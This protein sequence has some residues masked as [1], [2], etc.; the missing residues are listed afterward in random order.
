M[1]NVKMG[2]DISSFK[3]GIA[4]AKSEVKTLDQQ[5]KMLDAT[6]KAEGRSEQTLN[7]QMQTLN[8]RMTAQKSIANQAEAALKAMSKNG[9]DPAS[10]AYQRMARE[11]LAAQTGM[12]ETQSTLNDLGNGA[13]K[14]AGGVEQLESGLNGI[15]KKIS[16]EQVRSGISAIDKGLESAAKKAI[17]LGKAIW[18]NI[19]DVA[20][21]SDDTATQAMI[22]NMDVED[23]QAYKKVFDTVGEITV[24]EWQKAKLKVQNAM[25]DPSKEQVD[26]LK[27]LGISTKEWKQMNGQSGPSLVA[28]NFEE[29]FWEIGR[30]LKKKVESGEMTQDLADTYANALFGK[31]FAQMNPM[32]ELGEDE[33]TKR[34]NEQKVASEEAI[35]KNAELNDQLIQL[36]SD[37]DSLKV[38]VVGG[39]APA[40]TDATKA[41]DGLLTS[42]LDYLKTPEGQKALEDMGTA[43][44]GLFDDLGKIDPQ[45][46]V[47]GFTDVFNTV[48]GSIQWLVKNKDG[49]VTAMEA[50][51]IGWGALNVTGGVLDVIKVVTGIQDLLGAEAAGTAAGAAWG[52]G[53]A[54]AVAKAAPWLIGM[55]T[56][57]NPGNTGDELG[58]NTIIDEQG[59]LTEEAKQYGLKKDDTG[60]VYQDRTQI[61]SEAAQKA[62]DLYRT[63]QLTAAG[64]EEL[65]AAV[66]NDRVYG[67]LLDQF[68][69]F[70]S[71]NPN[72]KEIEDIDL[73]EWLK[74]LE[75]PKVPIDPEVPAGASGKIA[76]DIGTVSVPVVFVPAAGDPTYSRRTPGMQGI[77]P[78]HANGIWAV[79]RDNYLALLHKEERVIPARQM[80]S[81]N[82]TSNMY[83]ENMTMNNGQDADG[84]AARV[85]A[86]NQRIMSGYGSI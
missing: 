22:L 5:M 49:V 75:P 71:A 53:F 26:I 36:Q 69:D 60:E 62:W 66:L 11:L 39:L 6:M 56:L 24:Q 17:N 7:Q 44:S 18:E 29:M 23:Y 1:P 82:F 55:Y 43:V 3:S 15:S 2:A 9:V 13:V 67:E 78:G 72:W 33:F 79:P 10:E 8:S 30:T 83:I 47:T 70:R 41:V 28:R 86:E 57:L 31:G 81:R 85:A 4:A 25:N 34:V 42:V 50:I 21:F 64:M 51:L 59:N 46:V 38:E 74:G 40:L 19:T 77:I 76:E 68:M 52:K 58:N 16:L 73:T 54:G 63:N 61:I 84:L 45:Q 20:R 80:T 37:F 32:F 48:V 35:Q 12:M 27:A 14:A 65:R